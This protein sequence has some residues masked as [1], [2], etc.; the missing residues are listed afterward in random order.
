MRGIDVAALE[1]DAR[2]PV[3]RLRRVVLQRDRLA[4]EAPGSSG[5]P[6][7]ELRVRQADVS[8]RVFGFEP[9]R[10][11]QGLQGFLRAPIVDERGAQIVE[12]LGVVRV[13]PYI[14][15]EIVDRP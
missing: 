4:E 9:E 10:A 14:Q 15:F 1:V 7:V 3:P 13:L 6:E 8:A 11:L 12:P 2:E 5:V